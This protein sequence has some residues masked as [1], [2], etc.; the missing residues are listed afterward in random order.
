V[1]E[2]G[3]VDA[4]HRGGELLLRAEQ[5]AGLSIQ[6]VVGAVGHGQVHGKAVVIGQV[7]HQAA[8]RGGCES[9]G[10]EGGGGRHVHG[11]PQTVGGGLGGGGHEQGQ[12]EVVE[13]AGDA[14][15][16]AHRLLGVGLPVHPRQQG[17]V[18][19]LVAE[20]GFQAA[21][22]GQLL[23]EGVEVGPHGGLGRVLGV[24]VFPQGLPGLPHLG[25][26]FYPQQLPPP[27]G[28]QHQPAA[29][30]VQVGRYAAKQ[31]RGFLHGV[32]HV[33][34]QH[35]AVLVL[36]QGRVFHHVKPLVFELHGSHLHGRGRPHPV[37]PGVV[38][39]S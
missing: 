32:H 15:L 28:L 24:Q 2:G 12:V 9:V 5:L 7:A 21:G 23:P 16:G 27:V 17:P 8:E 10:V 18:H 34:L 36:A 30:L 26:V 4:R 1:R 31:V 29:G 13:K 33:E 14:L 22:H 3:V 19:A 35:V 20:V 38:K 37:A 39:S 6:P 25:L 11:F